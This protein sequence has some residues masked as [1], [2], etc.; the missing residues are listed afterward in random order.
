MAESS[1][2]GISDLANEF[3]VTT[4]TIRFYEDKGMLSPQRQGQKRIFNSADR[5]KLKLIL[6]GKRLGFSLDESRDIIAMYSPGKNNAD[7]LLSLIE[8]MRDRR[9]HLKQ[10]MKD[11]NAMMKE[12]SSYESQC[13]DSLKDI[14]PEIEKQLRNSN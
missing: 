10:K 8:K 4:R 6:R 14:A 7:Q 3:G 12:L 1:T 13:M 9:Q 11:L 5:T 2:Y